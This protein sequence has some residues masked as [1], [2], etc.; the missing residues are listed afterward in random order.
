M[1]IWA[2]VAILGL[3]GCSAMGT[4]LLGRHLLQIPQPSRKHKP[5]LAQQLQSSASRAK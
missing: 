4:A 2:L 3:S 5:L 1:R